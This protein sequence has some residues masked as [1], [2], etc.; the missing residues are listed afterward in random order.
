MITYDAVIIGS[1]QG[2]TPLCKRLAQAGWKTALVEKR[3]IGGTCVNDGCTPTKAM[4]ASARMAHLAASAKQLGVNIPSFDVDLPAII[5]RKNAIVAQFRNGSKEGLEKTEN[6]TLYLGEAIFTGNKQI[7]IS[8]KNGSKETITAPYIFIDTGTTTTI[9][10]IKGMNT[11]PYLTSTTILDITAVPEHLLIIGSSYIGCEF[12]QMFKRFGSKVTMLEQSADFL[13][14]EDRDIADCLLTILQQEGLNIYTNAGLKEV[15]VTPQ[16]ILATVTIDEKDLEIACSHIL[17]A[18]GRSP[19]TKN[20]GLEKTGVEIDKHGFIKVN[21]Q[22]ETTQPGIYAIGDVKG[23]PAFTHISYDDYLVIAKNL[24]EKV[25]ASIEDRPIPYCMFTDPQL[26]RIGLTESEAMKKNL[27][28]KVA[29]LDMT[30]VARGIETGE[31]KGMIKAIVDT[32][33]KQILGAAVI[34]EQGG[35][36][37]SL[38]QMAMEGKVSYNRISEMIFAHSLYAESLNNLFMKLE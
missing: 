15:S 17:I 3:F 27:P 2:G 37:M 24:L 16:G 20:L 23:G 18:A 12:G 19:Q 34:G 32:G 4:V 5:A 35:E 25:H 21:N 36:I 7:E 31:T 1:G 9:P 29:K 22:L 26:G 6:L 33:T 28:Y 10:D 38:L 8:L 14:K 30:S 13:A 11:I